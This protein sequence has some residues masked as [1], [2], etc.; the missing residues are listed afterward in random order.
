MTHD[1]GSVCVVVMATAVHAV[2]TSV[3]ETVVAMVTFGR[4]Q[5]SRLYSIGFM[6]DGLVT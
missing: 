5:H 4:S 1:D 6:T 3:N 2:L